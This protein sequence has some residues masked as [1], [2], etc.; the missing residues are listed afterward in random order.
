MFENPSNCCPRDFVLGSNDVRTIQVAHCPVKH[1]KCGCFK[2]CKINATTT[3]CEK[4]NVWLFSTEERICLKSYQL[5]WRKLPKL[6]N[7][8][9]NWEKWFIHGANNTKIWFPF[10][11]S[12]LVSHNV[13]FS[14][15]LKSVR[16]LYS[17][18]PQTRQCYLFYIFLFIFWQSKSIK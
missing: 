4:C 12:W 10:R 11:G 13:C 7:R 16:F 18:S 15:A 17:Y 9:I 3:L 14:K 6:L 5:T 8:C 2:F 1:E